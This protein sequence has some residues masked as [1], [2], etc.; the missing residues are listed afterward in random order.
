[1]STINKLIKSYSVGVTTSKRGDVFRFS[2]VKNVAPTSINDG[3]EDL[4]YVLMTASP[5]RSCL[6]A[7]H[8][9]YCILVN[10]RFLLSQFTVVN[11][12]TLW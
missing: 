11:S 3:R 10:R 9:L 5:C 1:M 12:I 2:L 4:A 7:F 8:F 6:L